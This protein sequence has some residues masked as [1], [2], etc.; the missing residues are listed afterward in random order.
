MLPYKELVD[1]LLLHKQN[2]QE[3][4]TET[5]KFSKKQQILQQQTIEIKE[6]KQKGTLKYN[7]SSSQT[8]ELY[9][10]LRVTRH[11]PTLQP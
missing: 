2:R 4:G 11:H 7:N 8:A 3:K 9:P 1:E 6:L 10:L 5:S